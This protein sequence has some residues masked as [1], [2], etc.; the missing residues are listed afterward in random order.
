MKHKIVIKDYD[1][2]KTV[3]LDSKRIYHYDGDWYYIFDDVMR[4]LDID[5]EYKDCTNNELEEWENDPEYLEE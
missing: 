1:L 2:R 5:V 4:A 3:Y